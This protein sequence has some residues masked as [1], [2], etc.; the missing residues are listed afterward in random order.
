MNGATM[1]HQKKKRDEQQPKRNKKQEKRVKCQLM[2]VDEYGDKRPASDE[3]ISNFEATHPDIARY[4][5]DASAMAELE[6]TSV[7]ALEKQRAWD[8]PAKKLIANLWRATHAWIFHEP[9]DPKKLHIDDY[10]QVITKPMDLGTV[11]RKLTNNAYDRGEEVMS[12]L[13]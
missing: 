6:S 9:V 4:W 11:K 8:K 1:D 3:E 10:F 2:I 13:E 7:D 5:Q 12:D